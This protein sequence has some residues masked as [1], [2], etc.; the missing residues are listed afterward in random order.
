MKRIFVILICGSCLFSCQSINTLSPERIAIIPYSGHEQLIYGSSLNNMDTIQLLGFRKY[1]TAENT[2]T[3]KNKKLIEHY[4]LHYQYQNRSDSKK[5][6][7]ELSGTYLVALTARETNLTI[8]SFNIA[9]KEKGYFFWNALNFDSIKSSSTS[10]LFLDNGVKLA[11]VSRIKNLY[12][13]NTQKLSDS[14]NISMIYW[15]LSKGLVGF[16]SGKNE[17]WKL[18]VQP[19]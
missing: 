11:D 9:D 15:S 4:N 18:K 8:I 6:S 3:F 5:D 14:T 12:N 17:I 2:G 10:V 7:T 19:L 16:V 1:L 13:S